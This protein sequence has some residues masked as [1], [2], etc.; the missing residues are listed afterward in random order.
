MD[1]KLTTKFSVTLGMYHSK[2]IEEYAKKLKLPL[3]RI[4]AMAIDNEFSK[5][6]P[7][8]GI[9]FTLYKDIQEDTYS[10]QAQKIVNYMSMIKSAV[11]I[12]FLYSMRHDIGLQHLEDVVGGFSELM[13]AGLLTEHLPSYIKPIKGGNK[14]Y[15]LYDG[16]DE[17]R[18]AKE[19]RKYI[20]LKKKF[21]KNEENDI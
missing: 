15:K 20:K 12:D 16:K 5:A 7:F 13:R 21:S 10:E 17:E 18:E 19:Y 1:S 4:I 3:T 8:K 6:H 11:T 9:D 2:K 14:Y